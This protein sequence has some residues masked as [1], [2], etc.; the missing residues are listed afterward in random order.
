MPRPWPASSMSVAV[1]AVGVAMTIGGC[2]RPG[3]SPAVPV[4]VVPVAE[5]TGA[6][7]PVPSPTPAPASAGDEDGY[8]RGDRV[9]VE[10]QGSWLPATLVERRG[11][12][13]RVR[14]TLGDDDETGE[15]GAVAAEET[16]ERER[17]R[18]PVEP[19]EDEGDEVDVDP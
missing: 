2:A 5:I 14:Y 18:T 11:D 6:T 8:A 17:I 16:V 7:L 4:I 15:P 12:R 10:W 3:R 13:W 9:E 1:V 19:V